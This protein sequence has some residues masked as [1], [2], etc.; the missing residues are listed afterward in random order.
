MPA[1]DITFRRAMPSEAGA[2]RDIVVRSTGHWHRPPEYLAAATELM[3]L[4]AEDLR[5]DEAWVVLVGGAIAG[6]YRLS[7]AGDRFEIEEFHLEPPMVGHGIGR[8]FRTCA[9]CHMG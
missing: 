1:R 4:S 3:D 7:R 6:F 5:R 8:V 9:S 2:M